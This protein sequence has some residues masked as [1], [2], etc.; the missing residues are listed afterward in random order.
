MM[1][2]TRKVMVKSAAG[3]WLS[4]MPAFCMTLPVARAM[5]LVNVLII[6]IVPVVSDATIVATMPE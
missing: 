5:A 6:R 1:A 2:P 4:W 3:I